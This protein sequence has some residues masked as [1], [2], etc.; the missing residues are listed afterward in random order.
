MTHT[1]L[2]PA[3]LFPST[4]YGFSQVVVCQPG[5]TVYMSGQVAWDAE[6]EIGGDPGVRSQ[7]E[8]AL[9]NVERAVQAAGGQRTDI[10]SLRL[11]LVG[12]AIRATAAVS[13]ALLGF[14]PA[15]RLPATS[16]IGVAA[17]ANPE[18]LIE[19]EA[20]AVIGDDR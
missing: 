12:E 2:N 18:F 9:A 4:Q 16:W 1:Y 8:R 17:L 10:I 11:Y 6:Q 3:N 15:D 7:A 20:V 14:F 5:R 19:I 13:D